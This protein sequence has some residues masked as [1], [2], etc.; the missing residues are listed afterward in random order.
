[1]KSLVCA[2]ILAC[3]PAISHAAEADAPWTGTMEIV[4]TLSGVRARDASKKDLDELTAD[5]E[6]R[7]EESKA[8]LLKATPSVARVLRDDIGQIEAELQRLALDNG[9]T[10]RLGRTLYAITA[11]RILVDSDEGRI[12]I[13]RG[14]HHAVVLAGGTREQ[15][16]LSD[17]PAAKK[18]SNDD[19]GETVLGQ[20]TRRV[21]IKAEDQ[22][23]EAHVIVGLP[24][25]YALSLLPSTSDKSLVAALAQLPGLPALV[26]CETKAGVIRWT[27]Q[28]LE[29]GDVDSTLFEE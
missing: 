22:E 25:P 12:I 28:R 5:L 16:Q 24:N 29:A 19:Q 3:S 15:L 7:L 23:Y 26:E 1:M 4:Q 11:A 14:Q 27:L 9:G 8:Q 21:K 18:L 2:L 20:P 13:D 17:P 10:V 6:R